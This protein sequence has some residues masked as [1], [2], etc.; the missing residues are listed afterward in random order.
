MRTSFIQGLLPP[1]LMIYNIHIFILLKKDQC[2]NVKLYSFTPNYFCLNSLIAFTFRALRHI[3]CWWL[4]KE[5][6]RLRME[7]LKPDKIR[8]KWLYINENHWD[9]SNVWSGRKPQISLRASGREYWKPEHEYLILETLEIKWL[10]IVIWQ[11]NRNVRQTG[12]YKKDVRMEN[13]LYT[14]RPLHVTKWQ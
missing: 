13:I 12:I 6:A 2:K 5:S 8:K 10:L 7:Y 4:R 11:K 1:G 9:H 3:Y 14:F